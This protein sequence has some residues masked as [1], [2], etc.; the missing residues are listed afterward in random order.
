MHRNLQSTCDNFV[1]FVKS[2]KDSY[3]STSYN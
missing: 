3:E 1:L 2:I